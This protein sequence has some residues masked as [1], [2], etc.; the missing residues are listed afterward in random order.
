MPPSVR[1]PSP[2]SWLAAP[3]RTPTAEGTTPGGPEME[4]YVIAHPA[5]RAARSARTLFAVVAATAVALLAVLVLSPEGAEAQGG[6]GASTDR[7]ERAVVKRI[8]AVRARA[9]LRGLRISGQLAR[10]ADGHSLDM[11]VRDFFDHTSGNGQPW[12][13]RLRR[14]TRA[15]RV[16]ETIAWTRGH[17]SRG[18][19]GRIV[20][21]WMASPPHR[22]E[23]LSAGFRRIGVGRRRG[24]YGRIPVTVF[25]ADFSSSR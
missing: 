20:S 23:L 3:C 17:R 8:N 21:S 7:V 9:G 2:G 10:S 6:H 4:A 12:Y 24:A 22:A 1:K 16:G 19:A 13:Q 11:L 18:Q 5:P 15:Y 14:Y 25:T